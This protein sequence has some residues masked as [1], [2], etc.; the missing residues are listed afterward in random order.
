VNFSLRQ[1]QFAFMLT[2]TCTLPMIWEHYW[3]A[4]C[5]YLD[6]SNALFGGYGVWSFIPRLAKA[7]FEPGETLVAGIGWLGESPPAL[8]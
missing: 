3:N 8:D 1:V 7:R 6:A 5:R 2:H 4:I